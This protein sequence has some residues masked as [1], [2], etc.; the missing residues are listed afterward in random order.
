MTK[1]GLGGGSAA[2]LISQS[3]MPVP[4]TR[5][6]APGGESAIVVAVDLGLTVDDVTSTVV[7]EVLRQRVADLGIAESVEVLRPVV[8]GRK[9]LLA[10]AWGAGC[11]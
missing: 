6:A 7:A 8:P 2:A 10:G 5:E 11:A 1:F 9:V 3:V 4:R